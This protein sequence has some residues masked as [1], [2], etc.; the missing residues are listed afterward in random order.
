MDIAIGK[1]VRLARRLRDMSL[2]DLAPRLGLTPQQLQ[3]SEAGARRLP[4][5]TI[6]QV[7]TVLH[8]PVDWFFIVDVGHPDRYQTRR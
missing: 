3:R 2:A 8:L 1:R 4:A 7:A 6:Y 5:A